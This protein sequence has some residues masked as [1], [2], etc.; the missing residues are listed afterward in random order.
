[1]TPVATPIDADNLRIRHEFLAMPG[2]CLSVP[3]AA[4]L[5]GVS[6]SHAAAMLAV[7][8]QEGFLIYTADSQY[9][10]A[11]HLLRSCA[12]DG[13]DRR[14]AG[15]CGGRVLSSSRKIPQPR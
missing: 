10:R 4:R 8:E 13:A 3:Q 14:D 6:V 9:R 7:M 15:G 12:G 11:H 1:M 2:M 5:L